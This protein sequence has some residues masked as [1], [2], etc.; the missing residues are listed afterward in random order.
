MASARRTSQEWGCQEWVS[1][2][3]HGCIVFLSKDQCNAAGSLLRRICRRFSVCQWSLSSSDEEAG[4]TGQA[5]DGDH[6]ETRFPWGYSGHYHQNVRCQYRDY[7]RV[8][9]DAGL[10]WQDDCRSQLEAEERAVRSGESYACWVVRL[11][12]VRAV[13][14]NHESLRTRTQE[15][16]SR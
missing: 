13:L 14:S 8:E 1:H 2:W 10:A 7:E 3:G 16:D 11:S 4:W 12:S 6:H 9:S 15:S 5:Q